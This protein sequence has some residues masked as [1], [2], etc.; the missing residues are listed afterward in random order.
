MAARVVQHELDHLDGMLILERTDASRA[1]EALATLRKQLSLPSLTMR[2]AVAATAPFGADVLERL[3]A[4]HEVAALLT[5]PDARQGAA[6][7]SPHRPPR[8]SPSGSGSRCCSRSGRRR[9]SSSRATRS[10]S[11]PTA[12]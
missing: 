2:I 3:A 8:S 9:G 6:A 5:R 12:C 7:S 4:R 1:S 11:P 10:S